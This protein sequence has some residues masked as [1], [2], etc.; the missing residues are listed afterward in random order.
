[1]VDIMSLKRMADIVSLNGMVDII[2]LTRLGHI[3][4]HTIAAEICLTR[5]AAR[6]KRRAHA[7]VPPTQAH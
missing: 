2:S 7:Q 3:I 5:P 1:M 4:R 6:G